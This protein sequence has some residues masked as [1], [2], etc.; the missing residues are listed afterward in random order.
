LNSLLRAV[1]ADHER[2][3]YCRYPHASV[4]EYDYVDDHVE[5][6]QMYSVSVAEAKAKLSEILSKVEDGDEVVITRRGRPIARL[7]AFN[8]CLKPVRSLAEFRASI[9]SAKTPAAKTIRQMRDE[10]F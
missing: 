8:K 4:V 3:D 6:P 7:A 10:D 2:L 1:G 5:N 9:P